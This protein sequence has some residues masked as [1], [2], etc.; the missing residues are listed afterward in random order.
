MKTLSSSWL[1]GSLLTFAMSAA[2]ACSAGAG[3]TG[4]SG[5]S[6]ASGGPGSGGSTSSSTIPDGT[7][8]LAPDPIT[9]TVN[10]ADVMVPVKA[11]SSTDGDV[12]DRTVFALADGKFG[13]FAGATLTVPAS[14]K[15]GGK[16]QALGSYGPQSGHADVIIDLH[17][18]D[19]VDPSAPPNP[20][21]WF[22]NGGGG[23]AP[24]WAYPFDNTMIPRNQPELNF[25][26]NAAPGAGAYRLH[27]EGATYQRDVYLG[28]SVC[29]GSQCMYQLADADWADVTAGLAGGDVTVS[30]D[31]SAG[32]TSPYGSAMV[33]LSFSPEDVKGGVYYWSTTITGI[34][35]VP[36]G[37]KT[38]SVFVQN[39]P[40]FGCVGCHAV[41]PDGKKVAME[42]GS[43]EGI[44]GGVVAGDNGQ[45]FIVTPPAA[46]KWNLQTFSPDGSKLLVNWHGTLRLIDSTTGATIS[47]VDPALVGS[48][49]LYAQPEWSPDGNSI[50]FVRMPSSGGYEWNAQNTGD[51]MVMP[52]NNGAFGTPEMI[53]PASGG[54]VHFYPTWTPDSQWIIFD[55]CQGCGTYNSHGTR[56]RM[57]RAQSGQTPIELTNATHAMNQ[58]TNWPRSAPFIQQNGS[59]MFF[60][61]SSY[62]PYGFLSN[63]TKPQIWMTAVDLGVAATQPGVDPSYSPFWL[64]FQKPTESNH[65][66][67]WTKSVACM[68]SATDCP[69]GFVCMNG[70]CVK[71]DVPK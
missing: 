59:L 58:G 17:A 71:Q 5:G 24:T 69:S 66:A 56:L 46:G 37:A 51:I 39:P 49:Y 26:W 45:S 68:D 40:G 15:T 55:S 9:V 3:G 32:A 38:A 7:L 42:F 22:A 8:T 11:Q 6:L 61:F 23:P 29:S 60:T 63:G 33:K 70:E 34:Y 12:T 54:Q 27:F 19:I 31:A 41:S 18:P 48:G 30:I 44:G 20:S 21:G 25:Q 57:V 28:P 4:G 67:T 50:V 53:V 35:R 14:I 65:L 1:W 43:A 47:N 64:T 10:G 36:L 2:A 16:T 52:Y 13:S 62:V